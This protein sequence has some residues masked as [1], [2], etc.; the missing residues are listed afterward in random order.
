M[1]APGP[2]GTPAD[3]AAIVLVLLVAIPSLTAL[4]LILMGLAP[5]PV[6][7][8]REAILH[9]RVGCFLA[10]LAVVVLAAV[11]V[12]VLG[13]LGGAGQVLAVLVLAALVLGIL[14]GLPAI[15]VLVGH[16][17]LA[18]S[19][20]TPSTLGAATTGLLLVF[21]AALFPLLGWVLFL[22]L[23]LTAL[24]AVVLETVGVRRRPPPPPVEPQELPAP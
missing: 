7:G 22:F 6:N 1:A 5:G 8:A 14:I 4:E 17:V 2:K 11:V 23:C 16:A 3:A 24:G 21:V 13:S 15:G 18:M 10:G 12:G 19:A 9:R 20:R